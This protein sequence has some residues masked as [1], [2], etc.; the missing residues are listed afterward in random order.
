MLSGAATLVGVLITGFAVGPHQ[1][2][3]YLVAARSGGPAVVIDPG[4]EAVP[5][6][7]YYFAVNDLAPA[8]VL[9]THGHGGHTASVFDLC[10]GWQIPAYLHPADNH[11][12]EDRPEE[13]IAVADGVCIEVG[14]VAVTADHTPGHTPG[15]VTYRVNADTDEGSAAVAFTGDTLGFRWA[16]RGEGR[17]EDHRRLRESVGAKLLVLGDDTVVLPGH[18]TSTTIGGERR[19]NPHCK[20]L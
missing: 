18:G 6:L 16:G 8:A 11:L 3:C 15:S 9:L 17:D 20:D 7:E 5:T 10:A 1:T 2:N 19:F 12:L 13:L 4:D 14:E